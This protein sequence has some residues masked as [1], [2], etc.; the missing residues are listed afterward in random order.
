MGKGGG[1]DGGEVLRQNLRQLE[2]KESKKAAQILLG[3]GEAKSS[4]RGDTQ[5]DSHNKNPHQETW[6]ATKSWP[7]DYGRKRWEW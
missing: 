4:A 1:R 6:E 3:R 2:E 7:S 5:R